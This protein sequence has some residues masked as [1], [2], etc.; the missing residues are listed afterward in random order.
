M[1]PYGTDD[2][3]LARECTPDDK[4][5]IPKTRSGLPRPA[6][7]GRG[8]GRASVGTDGAFSRAR[9]AARFAARPPRT[10]SHFGWSPTSTGPKAKSSPQTTSPPLPGPRPPTSARGSDVNQHE[11]RNRLSESSNKRRQRHRET[12]RRCYFGILSSSVTMGTKRTGSRLSRS[13]PFAV[14]RRR[15]KSWK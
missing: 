14:R 4:T 1:H 8:Q 15:I 9:A 11:D 7:G 3:S 5:R 10:K 13:R 2:V 6:G 12:E